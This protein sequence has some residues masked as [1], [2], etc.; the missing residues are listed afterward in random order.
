[1]ASTPQDFTSG[2]V[3]TDTMMD[4]LPQGAMTLASSTSSAAATSGTTELDVLTATAVT[5]AEAGRRWRLRWH[6]LGITGTVAN[7]IFTV[8]IKEGATELNA[9]RNVTIVTGVSIASGGCDFEAIVDSPTLVAHTYKVTIARN[10]GT[11]TATVGAA[12]T[13][14]MTLTL[15][16]IGAA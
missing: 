11:G 8:R 16:D 6:C 9:S 3:L 15:E 1:M 4:K 7:D 10:T 14:P 2:L 5:P 13:T 12:A